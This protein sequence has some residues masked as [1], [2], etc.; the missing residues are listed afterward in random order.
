MR[1]P[2]L[3]S[4]SSRARLKTTEVKKF[5]A[6]SEKA[7]GSLK[8]MKVQSRNVFPRRP[9]Q[10]PAATWLTTVRYPNWNKISPVHRRKNP[11]LLH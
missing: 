11:G 6:N 2:G 5:D 10:S 9:L 8:E 7:N 3:A 1:R 4:F